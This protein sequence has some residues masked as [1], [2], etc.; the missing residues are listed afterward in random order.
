MLETLSHVFV[1]CKP[2][3]DA[4]TWFAGVWERIAP[5]SVSETGLDL[6]D[7]SLILLDDIRELQPPAALLP[8]WTHLRLLMLQSIWDVK[9]DSNG[10][11][12]SGSQVISRF[13]A[14]LQQQLRQD[15]ARTEGDIRVDSGVPLSWLRGRNPVLPPERFTAK[16]LG[17]GVIYTLAGGDGPRVCLPH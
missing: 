2:A 13:V 17:D 14:A 1:H 16:W 5:G 4:W 11:M 7:D 9:T 15:W 6:V 3:L 12:Y 8:L 10:Q